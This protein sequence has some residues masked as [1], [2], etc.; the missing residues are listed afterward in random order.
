MIDFKDIEVGR[1]YCHD[2]LGLVTVL[3][4]HPHDGSMFIVSDENS[5]LFYATRDNL[6]LPDDR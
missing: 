1:T 6:A 3:A 4:V 2:R 5:D